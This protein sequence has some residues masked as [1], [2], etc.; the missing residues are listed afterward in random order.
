MF[1]SWDLVLA[2]A[3]PLTHPLPHRFICNP[4]PLSNSHEQGG[5]LELERELIGKWIVR[6][7]GDEEEV[8][9]HLSMDLINILNLLMLGVILLVVIQS[10]VEMMMD[11]RSGMLEIEE[12]WMEE[13]WDL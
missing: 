12:A 3:H 4:L 9:Q 5:T 11:G 6:G 2:K 10:C 7:K 13:E 8:H 1:M